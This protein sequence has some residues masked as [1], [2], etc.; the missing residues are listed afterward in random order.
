MFNS[1]F[2]LLSGDF[3]PSFSQGL[4]TLCSPITVTWSLILL[5]FHL[6]SHT[7]ASRADS[8]T[9]GLALLP[10]GLVAFPSSAHFMWRRPWWTSS[11]SNSACSSDGLVWGQLAFDSQMLMFT[12]VWRS[13]CFEI[14][15][16]NGNVLLLE[17][18][19]SIKT[20]ILHPISKETIKVKAQL[21]E[22]QLP[23]KL[24]WKQTVAALLQRPSV[25]DNQQI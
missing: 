10:P 4:V 21:C 9:R 2:I 20:K 24:E 17:T 1:Y 7:P 3:G 25:L 16:G 11:S 13:V 5:L 14:N 19:R 8:T 23:V 15:S 6:G 22:L 18:G 12:R